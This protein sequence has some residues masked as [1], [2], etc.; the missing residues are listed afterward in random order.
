[1]QSLKLGWNNTAAQRM[2]LVPAVK[3]LSSGG[4]TTLIFIAFL[5]L[6]IRHA[7][8]S[9]LEHVRGARQLNIHVQILADVNVAFHV[10]LGRNDVEQHFRRNGSVCRQQQS[11]FRLGAH[12]P[13]GWNNTSAHGSV[14]RQQQ[15]SFRL[16][17]HGPSGWNNTSAQSKRFGAVSDDLTVREPTVVDLWTQ[18]GCELVSCARAFLSGQMACGSWSVA[19]HISK[20][21]IALKIKY[22]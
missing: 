21:H 3:T 1:M 22:D 7:L 16:G 20:H 14:C 6:T 13:S 2:R 18:C 11:S 4:A 5:E 17:A 19:V 10:A 15:R 9:L 8:K 12:G